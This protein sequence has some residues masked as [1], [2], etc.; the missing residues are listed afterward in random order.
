M[1]QLADLITYKPTQ[2]EYLHAVALVFYQQAEKLKP[3]EPAA[4]SG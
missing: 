1:Q 3:G 4:S 2:K